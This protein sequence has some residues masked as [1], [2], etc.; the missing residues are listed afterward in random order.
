MK[1]APPVTR[2]RLAV[3]RASLPTW[4]RTKAQWLALIA[5]ACTAAVAI[6]H[7]LYHLVR[8]AAGKPVYDDEA[9]AGLLSA[10]PLA[11]VVETVMG[12]RGGAPLHF[13]LALDP[14]PVALRALSIV[15]AVGAVGLGY[16]LGRRL[17][18]HVAGAAAA[19]VAAGS[20]L[21]LIYGSFGRMY[22][23]FVFAAALAADLFARALE[24]RTARAAALAALAALLLPAAHPYGIV[25]FAVEAAVG[26]ALWR[27]RPLRPALPTLAIG[28]CVTP[29]LVADLRLADRFSVGLG[30]ESLA[31]ERGLGGFAREVLG[32]LGGATGFV[33]VLL[34]LLAGAGLALL[35]ARKEPFAA[36]AGGVFVASA[37]LLVLA[38][39]GD[40]AP[41][42]SR[43][44][45]FLLPVWA[46]LVGTAV[47]RLG[48]V[49][50]AALAALIFLAHGPAIKDPRVLEIAKPSELSA[51]ADSV[52]EQVGPRDVLF[53]YSPVYLSALPEAAQ[54]AVVS[55]A[56]PDLMLRELDD[57]D[58][59]VLRV[60]IAVPQRGSWRLVVTSGPFVDRVAVLL[61][62]EQELGSLVAEPHVVKARKAVAAA[63]A[64]S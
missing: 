57:A 47:A 39:A 13:V 63:L 30:G 37:L 22:A 1:P 24:Q 16:D 34:L 56:R 11:E 23:L 61:A 64:A 4:W 18:G 48:I 6:G 36:F 33:L 15:F 60:F 5:A 2:M 41:L 40:P 62:L 25:P 27:G 8:D 53:P 38:R 32:G 35:A 14:S 10:R 45:I 9:L 42:S 50:V 29:F 51:T 43:Y 31:Q 59:P 54:A 3:T 21:L 58:Y 46:A 26:L 17:G 52:R 44:F 12:D 19:A 28:L 55:R 20:D 49:G 7:L